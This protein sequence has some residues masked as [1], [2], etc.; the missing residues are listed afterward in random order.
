ML[1][2]IIREWV[3]NQ[4]NSFIPSESNKFVTTI[5]RSG[6]ADVS[7]PSRSLKVERASPEKV[8]NDIAVKFLRVQYVSIRAES[9]RTFRSPERVTRTQT[10]VTIQAIDFYSRPRRRRP[11]PP[12]PSPRPRLSSKTDQFHR[13]L[14]YFISIFKPQTH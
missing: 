10:R 3:F 12:D 5:V 6:H 9:T 13:A 1:I 14:V 8:S 7:K 2:K 4:I 11:P